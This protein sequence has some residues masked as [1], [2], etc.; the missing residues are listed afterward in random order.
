MTERD[1]KIVEEVIKGPLNG[2]KSLYTLHHP[3]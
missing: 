3:I 2:G 1:P